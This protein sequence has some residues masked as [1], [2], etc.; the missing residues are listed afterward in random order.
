MTLDITSIQK[1]VLSLGKA[2]N[3]YADK[4]FLELNEDQQDT[5]KA[6][7]IQNFE[8]TYE[9]CW[10]FM[11]RWLK[12]NDVYSEVDNPRTRNDIIRLAARHHLITDPEKW[13]DYGNARNLISHTYNEDVAET[14]LKTAVVFLDDAQ[15]LLKQLT[16]YND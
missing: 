4:S 2:V 10:K 15:Y 16:R 6:G 12:E 1:A 8:L 3:T 7:I 11:K 13:F 14:I 9:L 5:L